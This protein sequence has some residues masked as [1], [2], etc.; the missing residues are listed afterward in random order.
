M[1]IRISDGAMA[2]ATEAGEHSAMVRF[3]RYSMNL[4]M[5]AAA[6]LRQAFSEH[7][8]LANHGDEVLLSMGGPVLMIPLE[9]FVEGDVES[10]FHHVFSNT[11]RQTVKTVRMESLGIVAA[12]GVDRDLCTVLADNFR[13]VDYMPLMQPVWKNFLRRSFTGSRRKVFA[14]LHEHTMDVVSF[15]QSQVR[16]ANSFAVRHAADATFYLMSVWQQLAMDSKMDEMYI[17]GTVEIMIELKAE[18]RKFITN[19]S[20]ITPASRSGHMPIGLPFDLQI[21]YARHS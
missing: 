5:S 20:D 2:F 10:L 15:R 7:T 6:N 14:Y 16:F 3:E 19:V 12:F 17:A 18:L 1:T 4:G 8:L 9:E 13:Q 21:F 11:E